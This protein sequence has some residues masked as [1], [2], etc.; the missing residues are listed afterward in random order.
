MPANAE[1][2]IEI[3]AADDR[4]GCNLDSEHGFAATGNYSFYRRPLITTNLNFKTAP[5]DQ[6]SPPD[7]TPPTSVMW[8]GREPDLLSQARD[9]T[10]GHA[11]VADTLTD[12]GEVALL[13]QIVTFEREL[14]SAQYSDKKAKRLDDGGATGGPVNLSNQTPVGVF[15]PGVKVFDEFNS[16]ANLTGGR[17]EE[18]R[19]SIERGQKLFNANGISFPGGPPLERGAFIVAG[20]GGFNDLF[21]GGPVTASCSVC[22]SVP[23]A[24]NDP[25][26]PVQRDIGISGHAQEFGGPPP[27]TDLPIFKVTCNVGNFPLRDTNV[28]RTNDLGTAMITGKCADI[29]KKTVP[30]LRALASHEPFFSDGS[31]KTIGDVVSVYEKRFTFIDPVTQQPQPL[32]AQERRT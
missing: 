32:T 6:A 13:E 15:T 10:R 12:P 23:H 18:M 31:A 11:Q 19:A 14:F 26:A 21:G 3:T 9:A 5:D 27:S 8:D 16:W 24:G 17:K 22:H 2:S 20:V 25:V 30:Q 1:F 28:L 7:R 29:G 4:P